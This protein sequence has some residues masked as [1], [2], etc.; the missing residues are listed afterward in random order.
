MKSKPILLNNKK[1]CNKVL[2]F[3]NMLSNKLGKPI[4]TPQALDIMFSDDNIME[5]I[6]NSE[7]KKERGTKR[8]VSKS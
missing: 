8:Y 3:K 4:T 5:K 2:N 6:R 1:V 7:I